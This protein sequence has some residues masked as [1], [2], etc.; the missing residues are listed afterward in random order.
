MA[1]S[2]RYAKFGLFV[3]IMGDEQSGAK[4]CSATAVDSKSA[5]RKVFSRL[6]AQPAWMNKK[7]EPDFISIVCGPH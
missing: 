7:E 6:K 5:W 4:A 1:L 3:K 2:K